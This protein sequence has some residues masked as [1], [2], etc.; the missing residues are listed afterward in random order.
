MLKTYFLIAI[1]LALLP[2]CARS[3]IPALKLASGTE[4]QQGI[5]KLEWSAGGSQTASRYEL[6]EASD[7]SFAQAKIRYSGHETGTFISGLT[8]GQYYYRARNNG[9]LWSDTVQVK[10]Q[11]HSLTLAITLLILGAFVFIITTVVVVR[12]AKNTNQNK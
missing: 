4:T 1:Y 11:H 10:I 7:P 12:G 9:G 5:V 6:Q 3:E 2:I 8:N